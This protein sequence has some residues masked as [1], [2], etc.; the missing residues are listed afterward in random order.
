MLLRSK[1]QV[2]QKRLEVGS[3]HARK[4]QRRCPENANDAELISTRDCVLEPEIGSLESGV[5]S[6]RLTVV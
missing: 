6:T 4:P 5:W 2:M 3:D 1:W